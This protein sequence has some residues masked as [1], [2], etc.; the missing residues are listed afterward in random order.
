MSSNV[1]GNRVK[2][3]RPSGE[4]EALYLE[5][6]KRYYEEG[7]REQAADTAVRLE[8]LLAASPEQA[9]SIRGEEIRSIIAELRDDFSEAI[10][11][12]EAEIRK[13]LE[14]HARTLRT[15]SWEYVAQQYA[16]SDV[17]DRLDLL[18]I[19]YDKQGD[20][21]R[22][23][24]ILWESKQYCQ[25]HQLPFDAQDLLDELE[26]AREAEPVRAATREVPRDLLDRAIRKVYEQC[27]TSADEIVVLDRQARQFTAAVNQ[28][29][30]KYSK[31]SVQKVKRRLLALRRRGEARG[32]LPRLKR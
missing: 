25:S 1:P 20:S 21:D 13:M 23:L 14:L 16:F 30:S 6:L 9:R 7:D 19:L 28:R 24:A 31:V 10:Q 2:S 4:L 5:L 32:G 11:S 8:A 17:S 27:G 22:A 12:R 3:P 15:P 18:A 29:L 26:Q